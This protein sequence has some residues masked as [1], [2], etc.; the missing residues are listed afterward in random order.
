MLSQT[1]S[2]DGG[3]GRR[4]VQN[5]QSDQSNLP[6]LADLMDPQRLFSAYVFGMHILSCEFVRIFHFI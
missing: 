4:E 3:M 5:H 6:F 2:Q 1:S